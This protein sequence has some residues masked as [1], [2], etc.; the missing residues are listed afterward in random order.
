MFERR[1]E[2]R[3]CGKD[4]K[5]WNRRQKEVAIAKAFEENKIKK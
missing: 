3:I 1:N 2:L 5:K 4:K